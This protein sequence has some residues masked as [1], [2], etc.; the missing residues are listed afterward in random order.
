MGHSGKV[1]VM[2]IFIAVLVLVFSFQSWTNA[3]DIRD[4]QIDGMA[5]GDSLLNFFSEDEIQESLKNPT[6]YPKSKKMKVISLYPNNSGF[7]ERYDIH[8]KK[9]DTNYIIYSVKGVIKIIIDKCLNKKED[10]VS[11]IENIF[12]SAERK[13]Y[14]DNYRNTFGKSK[15]HI[16]DFI[17]T[18]GRVRVWC[19]EWDHNNE[20]VKSRKWWDGLSVN[21][22]TKEQIDFISNE[23][24][25]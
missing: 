4:F 6:Y 22:S 1:L 23:A 2:R 13:D 10:V 17:L 12:S 7:Y 16:T 25:K 9:N 11:E 19:M 20:L 5:T 15:A 21:M 8:I 3:E 18:N 14:T 24:Y